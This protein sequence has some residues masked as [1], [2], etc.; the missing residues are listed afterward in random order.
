MWNVT[1]KLLQETYCVLLQT[2]A[3]HDSIGRNLQTDPCK[4]KQ[5]SVEIT[6]M[7]NLWDENTPEGLQQIFYHISQAWRGGEAVACLTD[8]FSYQSK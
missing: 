2:R 5:S 8:L 4:R 1:S 3:V 6:K 7:I